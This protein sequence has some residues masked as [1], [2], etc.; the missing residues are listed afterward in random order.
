VARCGDF[1]VSPPRHDPEWELYPEARQVWKL[2]QTLAGRQRIV[3]LWKEQEG[4]CLVRGQPL[5]ME[6]SAWWHIH[7]R[8]WRS[9]GGSDRA[10]NLELLH[11]NCHRQIHVQSGV[12]GADRVSPEALVK[13]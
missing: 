3:Y 1:N 9:Q 6:E 7:H 2:K 12:N 4:R 11:A 5:R 8:R 13:A 10:D